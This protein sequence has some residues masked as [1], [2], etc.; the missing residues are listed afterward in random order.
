MAFQYA[1]ALTGG[2]AT[3][4]SSAT[5]ILSLYGFRF[6][7]ADKIAHQI[8]D[9]QYR[10]VAEMFGKDLVFGSK[11]DRKRLGSIIFS[12]PIKRK[13]L[14]S[15]LHPLIYQEIE[16]QSYREDQFK[17]P[18][19]IDIPLFFEGGRYPVEKS[20]VV[21]AAREQQL[22]R[23]MQR[24][25]YNQMEAICRIDSQMDIKQKRDRAT[26]VIDNSGDLRKLQQECERVKE[27]I[28]KDFL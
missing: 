2:I 22:Q 11:V 6:I 9:E 23:L 25:G 28:L 18:Y 27:A 3:G 20:L 17:K 15:L 26:Y 13:M 10:A 16:C 14:E 8:L 7:D 24:E 5:A 12:D 1:I 4:K 19:I 21:Y